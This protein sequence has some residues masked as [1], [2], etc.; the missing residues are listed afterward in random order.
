MQPA[1]EVCGDGPDLLFLHGW[2]SSRRLWRRLLPHLSSAFR[3]WTIDLPGFGQAPDIGARA[4]DAQAYSDWLDGF[5]VQ[6]GIDR[7]GVVGHS[8]G[9]ALTLQFAADQPRRVWAFAAV[10][11]VVTG[12]VILR[13]LEWLPRRERW[14]GWSQGLSQAVLGPLLAQPAL[15]RVRELIW[16][17]QRRIEDF[18]HAS[19]PTLLHTWTLL[20]GFDIRPR[21]ASVKAPGLIVLGSQDLN[22]PN[23]DGL[24]AVAELPN[25]RLVRFRAG[26]TLTDMHPVVVAGLLRGFFET[27]MAVEANA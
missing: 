4:I 22:V 7:C 19:N 1:F 6:Q 2:A 23:S 3:C 17:V 11:P 5:C 9:G 21:L 27:A 16:P 20:T 26:H 14:M 25:V 24:S 15:D 12:R 18:N 8:L 13:A 10:N